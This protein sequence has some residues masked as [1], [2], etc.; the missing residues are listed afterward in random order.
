MKKFLSLAV[1][2]SSIIINHVE[3]GFSNHGKWQSDH[4]NLVVNGTLENDGELSGVSSATL[5]CE[6]LT[7]SGLIKAPQI[8]IKAKAFAF[9]GK[10]ECSE[11]CLIIVS[12][13][14]DEEMFERSGGGEFIIL[15]DTTQSVI[16]LNTSLPTLEPIIHEKFPEKS[17]LFIEGDLS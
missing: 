5:C 9:S 16:N 7:G 15:Y 1:L 2:L 10:I 11:K 12:H 17:P 4:L 3:S 13:L 14:F 8:I 6:T